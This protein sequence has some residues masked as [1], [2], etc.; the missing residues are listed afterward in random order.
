MSLNKLIKQKQSDFDK[1]I[2]SV[3]FEGSPEPSKRKKPKSVHKT[4]TCGVCEAHDVHY[5]GVLDGKRIYL[6]YNCDNQPTEKNI[7]TS[8]KLWHSI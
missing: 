2:P 5:E 6:C 1:L 3:L 7:E 4:W 8:E